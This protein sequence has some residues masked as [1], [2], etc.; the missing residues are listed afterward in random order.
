[1]REASQG[2]DVRLHVRRFLKAKQK[3]AKAFAYEYERVGFQR[4]SPQNNF[5]RIIAARIPKGS[6]CFDTVSYITEKSTHM[7]LD[8]L[9]VLLNSKILDWYFR[10]GS[11]NSKVNEYQFNALPVPKISEE[12]PFVDWRLLLEG[13]Q[14]PDLAEL[15]CT[16]CTEPGVMPKP[17][18]DALISMSSRIQDIE[19]NR[20]LKSR[21]ER[22]RLALEGQPIQDTIDAILFRCYGLSEDDADYITRRL[23]EML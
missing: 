3:E 18:G 2:E 14:W 13:G 5:R 23:E 21:S 4:S 22:S 10:L 12:G 15:M 8:L 9:L 6:F 11:T 19:A 16:V 7:N 20:M 1:M 17:V